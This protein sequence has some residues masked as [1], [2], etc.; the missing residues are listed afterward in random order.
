MM[1]Y[2]V[3]LFCLHVLRPIETSH[4]D[5][6]MQIMRADSDF[7]FSEEYEVSPASGFFTHK[8]FFFF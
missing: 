2:D 3:M 6:I 4:F 1:D 8:N 5:E 7:K